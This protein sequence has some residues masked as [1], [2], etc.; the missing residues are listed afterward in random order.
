MNIHLARDLVINSSMASF[1]HPDFNQVLDSHIE[2]LKVN[3]NPSTKVIPSESRGLFIGDFYALLEVLEIPP[4]YHRLVMNMNGF[5]S[6][7][8]YNNQLN[9]VF[10]PDLSLVD[11]ILTVYNTGKRKL[12]VTPGE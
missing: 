9:S 8:K 2:F 4:K 11:K 10:V 6:P 7:T 3:G 12:I 5:T 1:F